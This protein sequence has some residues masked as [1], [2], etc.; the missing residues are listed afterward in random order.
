MKRKAILAVVGI[1]LAASGA[2]VAVLLSGGTSPAPPTA[3]D[4]LASAAGTGAPSTT[5]TSSPVSTT[6]SAER[7]SAR[8]AGQPYSDGVL[9]ED[10]ADDPGPDPV[11]ANDPDLRRADGYSYRPTK[12]GDHQLPTGTLA[13]QYD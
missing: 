7:K 12:P 1:V 13:F 11:F 3:V 4:N 5:I 9:S 10:P 2:G 8:G 6:P